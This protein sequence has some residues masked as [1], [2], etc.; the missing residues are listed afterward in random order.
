MR[1]TAT[2]TV[3]RWMIGASASALVAVAAPALAQ[4]AA[5]TLGQP[6]DSEIQTADAP[7][8]EG[9]E[10]LVTGIRASL[11]DALN[12]KRNAQGVVDAFVGLRVGADVL[13]VLPGGQDVLQ[14]AVMQVLGQGCLHEAPLQQAVDAPRVHV[15]VGGALGGTVVVDHESDPGIEA[16]I[17]ASGL[18]GHDHGPRSMYFGGVGAAY[19]R[20]DGALEAAGDPRRAGAALVTG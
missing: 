18:P 6:G 13:E 12:I 8:V 14:R 4:D 2:R 7:E 9:D 19:R 5:A 15:Q 16:A 17:A 1:G 20:E 10:I 11:R 3:S